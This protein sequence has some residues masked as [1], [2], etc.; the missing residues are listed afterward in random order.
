[1]KNVKLLFVTCGFAANAWLAKAQNATILL[2]EPKPPFIKNKM[3]AAKDCNVNHA[4]D[5]IFSAGESLINETTLEGDVIINPGANV[6]LTGKLSMALGAKIIVKTGGKIIINEA[7]LTTSCNGLWG[8]IEVLGD[9][10]DFI[11]TRSTIK[12]AENGIRFFNSN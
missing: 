9:S 4:K 10:N 8:G 7:A 3:Q 1:M 6:K 5:V 2:R 12:N 11:M